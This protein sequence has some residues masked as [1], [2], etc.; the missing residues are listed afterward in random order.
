M[1]NY[2]PTITRKMNRNVLSTFKVR[3]LKKQKGIVRKQNYVKNKTQ[4]NILSAET[5]INS[6][7]SGF[8]LPFSDVEK[9]PIES[10]ITGIFSGRFE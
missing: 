1:T 10:R 4:R 9:R 5:Q 2:F 8:R 7:S 3:C 6:H